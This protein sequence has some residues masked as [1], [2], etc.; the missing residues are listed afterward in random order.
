ALYGC[1]VESLSF[2]R[3]VG[4]LGRIPERPKP[5][6]AL[7]WP[8][9]EVTVNRH[10]VA[11]RLPNALAG[12]S[13][14]ELLPYLPAMGYGGKSETIKRLVAQ[15]KWSPTTRQ[16]M[17]ALL[18]D[19]DRY[20]RSNAAAAL[21]KATLTDEELLSLE[22]LLLKKAS[23]VRASVTKL[24]AGRKPARALE[25]ADRLLAHKK[26]EPRLG[27]LEVL[28]LLAGRDEA[29]AECQRRAAAY[30]EAHP[31][32]AEAEKAALEEVLD[33]GKP[34][35]TLD[36][37]LGLMTTP[38]AAVP[39]PKPRKAACVS[40]AAVACLKALDALVAE[41]AKEMITVKTYRGEE[42]V[43]L[44]TASGRF[45]SP[46]PS[47]PA[48]EQEGRFPLRAVWEAWQKDRPASQRDKDGLELLRAAAWVH[49]NA[50]H[51]AKGRENEE[52]CW[53]P[54]RDFW[55]NGVAPA[56]LK[57][58][59]QVGSILHWLTFLDPPADAPKWCLDTTEAF[60]AMVP[61]AERTRVIPENAN[62][63]ERNKDWRYAGFLPS[64]WFQ[65]VGTLTKKR[66]AAVWTDAD[67]ARWYRLAAW[68]ERPAPAVRRYR[69]S[70]EDVLDGFRAGAATEADLFDCLI[71]PEQ[72]WQPLASLT[73]HPAPELMK[74][75]R[76]AAAVRLCRDRVIEVELTRG[77][78]PTAASGV[79]RRVSACFGL[80][81]LMRLL[82]ALGT[83]PFVDSYYSRLGRA[84][85]FTHLISVCH[86]LP[87]DTP[88]RF[89]EAVEAAKVPAERLLQLA[90]IAP[91]WL[92]HVAQ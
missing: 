21:E 60:F 1:R 48:Q 47:R 69:L 34:K 75:E 86:P 29:V 54:A 14:E 36:D 88:E 24:L 20:A 49:V 67:R 25:C 90:F 15:K 76:L 16:A 87:A 17:L 39:E 12:R 71:G 28:R 18:G 13:P 91:Q 63:Q 80:D 32:L 84:E 23:D 70:L 9:N 77:E 3:L 51:W 56:G 41:H 61:A 19:K 11:D 64:A 74:D 46:D 22:P 85:V 82:A 59:G 30:A 92:R 7:L 31:D 73:L 38:R 6:G 72:N 81:L 89:A 27:G 37:A 43:A 83:R 44:G 26:P 2:D 4:L 45:P 33:H 52:A 10:W 40:K 66:T 8:W 42:T 5:L 53:H 78:N 65:N 62:W 50:D 79:A 35:P 58:A 57:Y 68:R 55:A